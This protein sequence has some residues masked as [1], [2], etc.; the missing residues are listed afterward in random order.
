MKKVYLKFSFI[1]LILCFCGINNLKSQTN[2]YLSFDGTDDWVSVPNAS[3]MVVNSNA[4]SMTGWFFDNNLN[5]GQGMMGFRTGTESFYLISL[6]SGQ[7]EARFINS[8]NVTSQPTIPT[9]TIIPNVWQHYAFVYDGTHTYFYLNGNLVGSATASGVLTI[10]TT[11]FAIGKSPLGTFNFYYNGR[12]DEVSLWNK[13]LTQTDVQDIMQNEINTAANPTGL[14]LYYKFNQGVPG[15]NNTGIT[16]LHTEVNTPLYDGDL[17]NFALTGTSSNF[18]GTFNSHFQAISFPPLPTK[19]T[20]SPP[21]ALHAS[22]SSGLPVSYTVVSG[23]ATL[24]NDSIVTLTGAGTVKIKAAQS[25]NAQFD[26]ATSIV[27]SFDVVNPANNLPII[28]PRHPLAGNVY[29]DTLSKIQLA[30]IATINYPSLFSIQELHFKIG[31]TTIAAHDFGNGHYTAWWQP[32]A[33]GS[34]AIQVISTSNLGAVA[35]TIVN[36]NIL[37]SA[38]DTTIQAFS[39]VLIN[40]GIPS[41]T[42]EAQLPSFLGA[43]DTIIA[44]LVVSCPTGGCGAWDHT[45]SVE[46]RS[47]E[48]NW[49]EVIRYIT[50]YATACSHYLLVTDY[51]S[52]LNGKVTFRVSCGTLDNGYL[53]ALNFQYKKGPVAHRYSQ[54]SQIWRDNYD[55]GNYVNLQPVSVNNYTFPAAVKASKMKLISTGHMGPNNTSNA[56]EFYDATHHIFVNNVSTFTQ[57]NWTTCNPNPDNCMPQSGTWQYSR[58]GWCPGAIAKPFDFDMTSYVPTNTIAL[59]YEFYPQYV[60]QCNANYPGCVSNTNCTCSDGANPFFVVDCNVINFFDN[61][62]PDPQIM[63]VNEVKD[64]LEIAVYPNPSK[65]IFNLSSYDKL[66]SKCNVI[67][68]S[69]MGKVVDQFEWRGNNISINLTNNAPGIY[70]MKISNEKF[71]EIKKLIKR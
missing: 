47:H 24:S 7:I 2:Q 66:D 60:D 54:V 52:L 14:L 58:A 63:T 11:P 64:K 44:N 68:Y 15:G 6:N 39:N 20:T 12:I 67:I 69:L 21:F 42:V 70:L 50:P 33:Y 9:G 29:M 4:M 23:P 5:Y 40:T 45:A 16:K 46:A 10:G 31:S 38:N 35:T 1:L 36:V 13:A 49:Y 53:Y 71:V 41:V 3:S 61:P 18:N 48:G 28:D 8:S 25:G 51:A 30:A 57:H 22:A 26:S 56:A 59:K 37:P 17:T 32:S 43:Y 55:F 19:L 62:P 65:G 34:Y 27:N